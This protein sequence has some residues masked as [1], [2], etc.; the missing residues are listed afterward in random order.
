[1]YM[2]KNLFRRTAL[3]G[4]VAVVALMAAFLPAGPAPAQ[5]AKTEAKT[6]APVGAGP[7]LP[8]VKLDLL[9]HTLSAKEAG[10]AWAELQQAI[11]TRPPTPDA[12]ALKEPSPE[13][14][15]HFLQPYALAI[16]DKSKDYYSRFPGDT[17]AIE[18]K[19]SEFGALTFLVD[20][21][22][23]TN[24][25]ARLDAALQDLL[26]DPKL[27]EDERFDLRNHAVEKAMHDKESQGEAAMLVEFEK[28]ARLLQKELPKNPK[29][30]A[31]LMD[32]AEL[33]EPDKS[34]DVVK[35]IAANAD[36]PAAVKQAA[37]AMQKQLERVGQPFPLKYA[38]I[39]GREV[40]LD[41]MRGKVVLVDFWATWCQPC[42]EMLPTVKEAYDQFHPKGFE[43]VGINLDG[44]KGSLTNFV[45]A[46]KMAWPQYFDG[47]NWA[48]PAGLAGATAPDIAGD[49]NWDKSKYAAEFG[50]KEIPAL[51]LVDK[52][53]TLRY[54]NG[55]FDFTNK[56]ARLLGE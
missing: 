29:V 54:I 34:R 28:G 53:G 56:I 52:K 30:L 23:A 50:V 10:A 3:F 36:A 33:S 26:A 8:G 55:G 38:A 43:I 47:T 13:E 46:Q 45:A 24:Q 11:T 6:N 42:V 7:A 9:A 1:M 44:E 35:E 22:A 51:W 49:E 32:L 4:A 25:Q 5:D 40:D 19:L 48:K 41:K 20:E 37:A 18:A 16:A 27:P 39:D 31:M 12:W 2:K 14:E 21:G 17:N 15:M